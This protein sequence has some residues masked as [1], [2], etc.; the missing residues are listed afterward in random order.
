MWPSKSYVRKRSLG[1]ATTT[2][3]GAFRT[4]MC[5][6]QCDWRW[7]SWR[8]VRKHRHAAYIHR[9][10]WRRPLLGPPPT[11]WAPSTPW[12]R[13]GAWPPYALVGSPWHP[14]AFNPSRLEVCRF[15]RV[16]FGVA[17]FLKESV[18]TNIC[19]HAARGCCESVLSNT[20]D[21][22]APEHCG[23]SGT[24]QGGPRNGDGARQL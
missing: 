9:G 6:A 16:V 7:M 12:P 8:C 20:G 24:R 10:L 1:F 4:K 18:S 11:P 13:Q 21:G 17:S 22:E 2:R 3:K 19:K 14:G 15:A 5:C 23:A